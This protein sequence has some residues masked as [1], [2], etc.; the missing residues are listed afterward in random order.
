MKTNTSCDIFPVLVVVIEA[1]KGPCC[2]PLTLL[3][4]IRAPE[5]EQRMNVKLKKTA[6][7]G[8]G[9]QLLLPTPPVEGAAASEEPEPDDPPPHPS[10]HRGPLCHPGQCPWSLQSVMVPLLQRANT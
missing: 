10:H 2:F 5:K 9:G 7:G 3:F 4:R 8:I 1:N 6:G